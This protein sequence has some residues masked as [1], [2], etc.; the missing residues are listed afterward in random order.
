[1]FKR[2]VFLIRKEGIMKKIE[3]LL[4]ELHERNIEVCVW[5]IQYP[6]QTMEAIETLYITDSALCQAW[7][8]EKKAPT[9]VYLHEENRGESFLQA[10]YMIEK[11]EELEYESLELAFLRLTGQ[12]WTILTTNRCNIRESTI[13]DVES[14]Y[15]IYKEPSI[16]AYMENL[17]ADKEEEI[18]YIQDYIR[19]VYGF[20]GY[21]MWTVAEKGSG[22]VIGRAG[23]NWRE[24]YDIP[25]LG[26]VIAVPCQRQ[27]YAYEV[28]SA[29]LEY[30][31]RVLGFH[32]FQ[33]LVMEGNV[34]SE[35]LCRKLGFYEVEKVCIDDQLY[36]RLLYE[37]DE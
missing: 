28:C 32:R 18:A 34:K 11:I 8:Q 17:Y 26:F 25:E 3:E 12:P 33:A 9:L 30:G 24:G 22:A 7:L 31:I 20:Y 15:E 21:G 37:L 19:N 5:D 16:T 29:I 1:M 23:L 2:V 13:E 14:F 6:V 27:G 4:R 36:T 35:N 10:E